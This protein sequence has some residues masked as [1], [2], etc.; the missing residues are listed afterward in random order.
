MLG[1]MQR[2]RHNYLRLREVALAWKSLKLH[3]PALVALHGDFQKK[4]QLQNHRPHR[5]RENIYV[6][7]L[8]DDQNI[9]RL[10]WILTSGE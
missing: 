8:V 2:L 4:T 5:I 10:C 3:T 7:L 1:N 9:T 6:V